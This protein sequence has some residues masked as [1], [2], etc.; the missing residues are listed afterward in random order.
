MACLSLAFFW[1]CY[2]EYVVYTAVHIPFYIFDITLIQ[3]L[4]NLIIN[5]IYN[6]F[7]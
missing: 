4:A 6:F 7:S 2:G 1:K 5:F 3:H